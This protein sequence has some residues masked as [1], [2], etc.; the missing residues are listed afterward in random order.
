MTKKTRKRTATPKPP[1]E[2]PQTKIG[3][4]T[5]YRS[6]P[7]GTP[8][9]VSGQPTQPVIPF[10]KAPPKVDVPADGTLIRGD[11]GPVVYV[12]QDG[13]KR[14]LRDALVFAACGFGWNDIV[15]LSPEEIDRI[16]V[17]KPVARQSDL[18]GK[19]A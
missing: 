16:P 3:E 5:R 18:Q 15:L 14:P 13:E 4:H 12:M 9:E 6:S 17:G 7:D 2:E 8:V 11:G 1:A 19:G 10:G